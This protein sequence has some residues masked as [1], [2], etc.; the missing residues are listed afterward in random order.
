MDTDEAAL[1]EAMPC[2]RSRGVRA[3]GREVPAARLSTRLQRPARPGRGLGCRP[4]CLHPRLPGAAVVPGRLR[5]LHLAL[6][7][8]DERRAGSRAD[9]TRRAGARSVPSASTRA[10]LGPGPGRSGDRARRHA[11]Q[12]EERERIGRALATLSEPHRAI[13]MLSDLEGLSYREIAEV[14][15]IPMGT[16]MSR[17]HN[18]RRRLRDALGPLWF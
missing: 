12:V 18:A 10:G 3:A 11:K 17:L 4:G 8:R 1:I 13:I 16:V 7:D 2:R 9:S 5:V 6:S 14:L 15:N